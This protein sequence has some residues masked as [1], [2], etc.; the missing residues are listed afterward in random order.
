MKVMSR[1]G[2]DGSWV[3]V[4]NGCAVKVVPIGSIDMFSEL[5]AVCPLAVAKEP[6]PPDS[7][8]KLAALGET[9]LFQLVVVG[10]KVMSPLISNVPLIGAPAHLK[11]P[12]DNAPHTSSFVRIILMFLLS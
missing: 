5:I 11:S 3:N 6:V 9:L 7:V 12:K 4:M 2:S 8:K 1:P 10:V